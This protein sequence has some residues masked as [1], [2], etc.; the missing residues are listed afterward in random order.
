MTELWHSILS[1]SAN[2][3]K[4]N[5]KGQGRKTDEINSR[6]FPRAKKFQ[7]GNNEGNERAGLKV[8]PERT[9]K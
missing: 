7:D 4:C 2:V 6:K 9:W 5:K 1:K 3:S 8:C